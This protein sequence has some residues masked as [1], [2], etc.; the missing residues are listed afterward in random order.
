MDT[1][2]IL[3]SSLGINI[4]GFA[5]AHLRGIS[6]YMWGANVHVTPTAW[7]VLIAEL[8]MVPLL[9]GMTFY[10]QSRKTDFL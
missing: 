3:C 7:L 9:L 2:A 6:M 1:V 5:F 10:I 8:V 4:L